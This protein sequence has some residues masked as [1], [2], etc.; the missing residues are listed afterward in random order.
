MRHKIRQTL[1][2]VNKYG[3]QPVEMYWDYRKT[4]KKIRIPFKQ[5]NED[6]DTLLSN[7]GKKKGIKKKDMVFGLTEILGLQKV[8]SYYFICF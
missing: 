2:R 6:T 1:F 5:F 8:K 7:G 4:K 3:N